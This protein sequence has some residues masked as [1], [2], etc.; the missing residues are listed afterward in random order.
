MNEPIKRYCKPGTVFFKSFPFCESGDD[1]PEIMRR[2]EQIAQD[3]FFS[4]IEVGKINDILVRTRVAR[5]FEYSGM[6]VCYA[7]QPYFFAH[8]GHT[9]NHRVSL[10]SLTKEKREE[11]I[12]IFTR[13]LKEACDLHATAVRF[14]S[15]YLPDPNTEE[16]RTEAKKWLIDSLHRICEEA[17]QWNNPMLT[18]KI[19]DNRYTGPQLIGPCEDALEVAQAV[20]PEHDNFGLLTDLSHFPLLQE[21]MRTTVTALKDYLKAFHLGN[22]IVKGSAATNPIFGDWQPRFG[23]PDGANTIDDVIDY[24]RVLNELGLI[25]P[26]KRPVVT[27]EVRPLIG[28]ETEELVLANSKRIIEEAWARA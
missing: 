5:I 21:D 16:N 6:E 3:T 4:V 8:D 24:F 22:T 20:C 10:C 25:G 7:A 11:A 28:D 12:N 9:N 23:V 2:A 18:M 17:K 15:G 13:C 1:F 19:F 14:P 27:A 26:D